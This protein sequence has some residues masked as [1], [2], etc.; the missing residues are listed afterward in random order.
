MKTSESVNGMLAAIFHEMAGMYRL[1]GEKNRFRALAYENASRTIKNLPDEISRYSIDHH[2]K[3]LS[4]IGESIEEKI[5]EFLETGRIRKYEELK[6]E[7]PYE[8][9]GL[10]D[11]SGFG[12]QTLTA[13]HE[14]LHINT[15]DE[16]IEA[17]SDGRLEMLKGFGKQKVENLK[18]ALKLHKVLEERMLLGDAL[19]LGETVLSQ[20]IARPEVMKAEL[21]G[22]LRRGRETIGDIDII[23][24]AKEKDRKKIM[25]VFTG[26][27]ETERV[28]A[29][30]ETK[31]SIM[32]KSPHRQADLRIVNEQEW[33]SALL[34]FTGS[35]EHN[36]HLRTMAKDR[37]MK[38]SEYGLF[39]LKTDKRVAGATEEEMYHALGL[40]F[41]P[42][43]MREDA[44]EIELAA[45]KK[46]PELVQVKDIR[47]DLQMHSNWSDG[48]ETIQTL[49]DYVIRHFEYDYIVITDHSRSS[50]IAGGR[51]ESAFR[52]QFEEIDAVNRRLKK[53]FVKKGVE[54]DILPD[55]SLDLSNDLLKDMDWVTASIHSGLKKD[56][57]ERLIRACANPYVNCIGH[58]S[59]I[60]LG[61][62][63]A[64]PVNWSRLFKAA[65]ETGTALEINAQQDRL[66][67]NAGLARK[68]ALSGIPLVIST[69]AHTLANLHFMRLGV[70]TA[71]RGWC[72]AQQILNT[73]TWNEIASFRTAKIRRCGMASEKHRKNRSIASPS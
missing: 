11:I 12:P 6:K 73:R 20:L 33:G 18:R 14:K 67:L 34:Y 21:A 54:V 43:E 3:K 64:Y 31:A 69:D 32:L 68:A 38:I 56:N 23:V 61:Q 66:D 10:I 46:I 42:P 28:L 55:G 71:R 44:G 51:D 5:L 70:M 26:L 57:T 72:T 15:K 39:D 8:L 27:N 52:K 22:S 16:L 37:G 19:Q 45:K 30:G 62:R 7:V 58:P 1:L 65:K 2:L 17:L 36:I 47:G 29:R 9:I 4:G 50:R 24:A 63:E 59:G 60:L 48:S 13:I 35:K 25:N 49:A 40:Q 41:I 53:E